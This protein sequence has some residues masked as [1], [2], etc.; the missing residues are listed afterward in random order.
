MSIPLRFFDS[1]PTEGQAFTLSL[2]PA[3]DQQEDL[4]RHVSHL[5]EKLKKEGDTK[6]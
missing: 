6:Q 3:P 4:H 5:F 2:V 1:H